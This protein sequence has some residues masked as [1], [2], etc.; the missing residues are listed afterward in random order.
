MFYYLCATYGF[1]ILVYNAELSIQNQIQNYIGI[2]NK[3]LSSKYTKD[4]NGIFVYHQTSSYSSSLDYFTITNGAYYQY[5][6]E[7]FAKL[8]STLAGIFPLSNEK[9]AILKSGTMSTLKI[10]NYFNKSTM[11]S[12][13]DSFNTNVNTYLYNDESAIQ[14]GNKKVIITDP[15]NLYIQNSNIVINDQ[16]YNPTIYAGDNITIT[17]PMTSIGAESIAKRKITPTVSGFQGSINY[18]WTLNGKVV[19]N[20]KSINHPT[21]AGV[22]T[23]IVTA[24]DN[25]NHTS[26]DYI[27][28]TIN[29]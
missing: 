10:H 5:T 16:T 12:I 15:W 14:I 13:T 21:A 1:K 29:P 6:L 24:T 23:Y 19:S 9:V 22:Y 18:V 25:Y 20:S 8:E 4:K 2:N 7:T 26:S 28:I 3:I 27:I 17:A 11:G